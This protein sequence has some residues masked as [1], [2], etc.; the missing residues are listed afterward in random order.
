MNNKRIIW[1]FKS[2]VNYSQ[3]GKLGN[4][5]IV[6]QLHKALLFFFFFALCDDSFEEYRLCHDQRVR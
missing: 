3:L 6:L 4:K 2:V 5:G 1:N